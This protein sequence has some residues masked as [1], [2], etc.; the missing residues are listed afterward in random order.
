MRTYRVTY[1]LQGRTAHT[2]L[3]ASTPGVA[4]KRVID[5]AARAG[6]TF[7]TVCPKYRISLKPGESLS[8]QIKC[9][10]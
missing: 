4:L 6:Y 7:A 10:A 2:E 1:S 9:I 3:C 8:V 5:G